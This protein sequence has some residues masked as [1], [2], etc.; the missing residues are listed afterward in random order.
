MKFFLENIG[1]IVA[2]IFI[3]ITT[4]LVIVN[5][6]MRYVLNSGLV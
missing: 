1:D 5:I 6:I 4:I 3:T 2:A